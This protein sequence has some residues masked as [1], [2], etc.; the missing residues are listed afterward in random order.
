LVLCSFITL[1]NLT[2][3][4]LKM[5]QPWLA[6]FSL[7]ADH[8]SR[9]FHS[10]GYY[11]YLI[12][13]FNCV[14]V[15]ENKW[16]WLDFACMYMC[17]YGYLWSTVQEPRE[18]P[19]MALDFVAWLLS[20]VEFVFLGVYAQQWDPIA[21][22]WAPRAWPLWLGHGLLWQSPAAV[23]WDGICLGFRW[24]MRA[25]SVAKVWRHSYAVCFFCPVSW[26]MSGQK[27]SSFSVAYPP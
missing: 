13:L 22:P 4:L 8:F 20:S 17:V 11:C 26:F 7:L 15:S 3:L 25:A 5:G 10:H 18:G 1:H 24:R 23:L 14:T 9:A 16:F 27:T 12:V 19:L 6:G 2:I 21:W